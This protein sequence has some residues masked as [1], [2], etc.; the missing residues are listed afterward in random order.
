MLPV[1]TN[2]VVDRTSDRGGRLATLERSHRIFAPFAGPRSGDFS[3]ARFLRYRAMEPKDS[4]H[5]LAWFDDGG[6]ALVDG[7][8]GMGRVVVWGSTMDDFWNDLVL[9]PVFL[10]FLQSMVLHTAGYTPEPLWRTVGQRVALAADTSAAN[11]RVLVSPS[12]A[13][14]RATVRPVELSQPGFY[15]LQSDNRETVRLV[16]VNVDRAESDFNTWNADELKAAITSS[17]TLA[18]VASSETLTDV[19]RE[20][21]Q[22][23]WWFLLV[24][25]GLLLLIEVLL[26][27]RL[28]RRVAIS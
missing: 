6:V 15:Q 3:A 10:P 21:R 8:A 14:D 28:S 26:A 18:S 13:R 9:Q 20:G 1:T 23:V 24:G 16:A 12:G 17:D 19:E 27:N 7:K 2:R 5:V 11:S 25:A 22:R 4:A